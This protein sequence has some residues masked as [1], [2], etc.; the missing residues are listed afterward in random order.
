MPINMLF[1]SSTLVK[2]GYEITIID[3]RVTPKYEDQLLNILP[4]A[5][6][7]GI[8]SFSGYQIKSGLK[9]AEIVK[10]HRPDQKIV[11]GGTHPSSLPKQM[12]KNRFVDIVV[13]GQG[14]KVIYDLVKA[15]ETSKKYVNVSGIIYKNG[16]EVV[17]NPIQLFDINTIPE[18]PFHLLD[19]EKYINPV[20]RALNYTT[21]VG[22]SGYC[23]FCFWAS[24]SANKWQAFDNKRVLDDIEML[25][26][27]YELK[28]I[29]FMD[30][31]FFR[32]ES[33]LVELCEGIL[34]R[35]IK[36]KWNAEG[37]VNEFGAL[38]EETLTLCEKAGLNSVFFGLES[39]SPRILKLM[40][41]RTTPEQAIMLVKKTKDRSF[42]ILFSLMFGLPLE[43]IEDLKL[44]G[45]FIKK[46]IEINP[47][48]HYQ[49]SVFAPYPATGMFNLAVSRG[50][51]PPERFED[52]QDFNPQSGNF[53]EKPTWFSESFFREYMELFVKLF[54]QENDY[55]KHLRT[56]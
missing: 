25:T 56:E 43:T 24:K 50:Y 46:S 35:K 23:T 48:I 12:L 4:D 7:F 3:E 29:K 13:R 51:Q 41:K 33:R 36:V 38:S 15:F 22:C 26:K 21:S 1:L 18:L 8:S 47:Q 42:K 9:A 40:N 16:R 5:V 54:P 34:K 17:S 37:R 53:R 55:L 30:A 6:F 44:T 52:W 20:T 28:I 31:N 49:R 45:E 11:W 39:V 27:K 10:K 2:E 14:E 19:V 32:N